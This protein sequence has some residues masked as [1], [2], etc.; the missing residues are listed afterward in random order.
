VATR[1]D[2]QLIRRA[3]QGSE[4]A[5]NAVFEL[6][7][8]RLLALIR[9]RM[10][11]SLRN[12]LESRD[13]LQQ[14]LLEAFRHVDQFEGSGDRSLMGWLGTIASNQIKDQAKFYR[15]QVRDVVR[16]VPL[17]EGLDRVAERMH[18]EVSRLHLQEQA[19]LL[20]RALESLDEAHREVILLRRF[21][22]LPFREIAERMERSA[23]ACRV[24]HARAMTALTIKMKELREG[25]V[26]S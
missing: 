19:L 15:R 7:G 23:D 9:L 24:L 10:G 12:Q 22:E 13:V 17:E 6:C 21:E 20:E 4:E 2:S 11:P 16:N 3:T 1:A 18:G 8:E 25:A 5:L 26:E 14:T